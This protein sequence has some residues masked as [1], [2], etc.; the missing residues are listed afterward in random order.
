[1]MTKAREVREVFEKQYISRTK[2]S[3]EMYKEARRYLAGGVPGGARYRR[4][5]PLYM[6][7]ARGSRIWDID[8]NEYIDQNLARMPPSLLGG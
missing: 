6:K 4:P 7:E 5:Y 3:S 8:G 1:M 2:K